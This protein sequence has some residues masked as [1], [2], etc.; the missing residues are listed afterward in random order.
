MSQSE[1]IST[2]TELQELRRMQEELSA[3]IDALQDAIKQHM[4]ADEILTAGPYKVT[5]KPVTTSR[6]DSKALSADHPDIAEQYTKITT[7]RRFTVK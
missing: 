6:I 2:L 5:W 4:G 7:T 1:I 3:E